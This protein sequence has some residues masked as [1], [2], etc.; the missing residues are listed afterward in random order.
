M[1]ADCS[2]NHHVNK[3]MNIG[4]KKLPNEIPRV[5]GWNIDVNK[6]PWTAPF[7]TLVGTII[8]L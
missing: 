8:L 6:G 4:W 2:E 5:P 3:I 1:L 7:N